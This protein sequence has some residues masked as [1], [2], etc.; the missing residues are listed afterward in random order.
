M[1]SRQVLALSCGL[2]E[3]LNPGFLDSALPERKKR[4]VKSEIQQQKAIESARLK[5]EKRNQKRAKAF[6]K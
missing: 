1:D 4:P 6:H 5:R 3:S 2:A